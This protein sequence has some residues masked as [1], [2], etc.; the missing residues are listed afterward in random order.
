MFQE[1][2]RAERKRFV[3]EKG[4]CNLCL[5][6]EH[7][8]SKC[9]RGRKCFVDGCG[10]RHHPLLHSSELKQS[11]Q[12]EDSTK[13]S[14]VKDQEAQAEPTGPNA[15][16]EHC[17]AT[18][19]AKRQVCLRVIPVKV[20]SRDSSKEK[21]TYAIR[22][23]GSNATLVKESLMNE[24]GL[25][26]QPLDFNLATMNNVSQE[27]GKSY[28]LY[29]QGLGQKEY[30]EVP[31]ALS[32]KDLSV[33]RYCIPTKEDI[34]KGR[35]LSDVHIPESKNPEV[36]PLIGTDVPEAHWRLEERRRRKKEPY[37]IRTP[38]GWSVAGSMGT[39]SGDKVLHFFLVVKM[40]SSDRQ[41]R[42]C[43]KWISVRKRT[44]RALACL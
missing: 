41:S 17:G 35:H 5:S 3:R 26:G 9:Q 40:I 10:R 2:S 28:F 32:I 43:L 7:F 1:K 19:A 18:D 14:K 27:S 15:Q 36:T 23:E 20:F 13:A 22:D 44:G 37:A 38:L 8:A 42:R 21:I 25:E 12:D 6:K 39:T 33:A 31:K 29:V 4:L 24:L 34:D 11:K 30:L 16:T